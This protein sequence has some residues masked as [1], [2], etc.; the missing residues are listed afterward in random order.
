MICERPL[1]R[2]TAA[3]TC[4]IREM[5]TRLIIPLLIAGALA[6]ACGP[7]SRSETPVALATA[8]PV[9]LAAPVPRAKRHDSSEPKKEVKLASHLTVDVAPNQV[10]LAL[11]IRNVSTKHAELD[12][13]S[14]QSYDFAVI[15]STGREVWRWARGRMFT[16]SVQNK[17]LGAGETMRVAEAW[18]PKAGR[19]TAVATLNSSNFPVEQRTDFVVR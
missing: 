8:Q 10:R 2:N 13:P 3:P 11:D 5:N 7:R 15:D 17:Q 14:G 19:Y 18:T 16:Q 4:P 12:F 9:K 1:A 6:F